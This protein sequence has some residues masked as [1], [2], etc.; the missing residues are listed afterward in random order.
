MNGA[1]VALADRPR[2]E[3]E[4]LDG[5]QRPAII[6]PRPGILLY[7]GY[8]RPFVAVAAA[9]Y[10]PLA[11]DFRIPQAFSDGMGA[12]LFPNTSFVSVCFKSLTTST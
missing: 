5:L 2:A 3:G 11:P 6:E 4:S 1:S 8:D 9:A 7:S 12:A 10:V